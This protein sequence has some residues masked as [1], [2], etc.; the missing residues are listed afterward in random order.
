MWLVFT[1]RDLL[2]VVNISSLLEFLYMLIQSEIDWQI[3]SSNAN[4]C[5]LT[6][7]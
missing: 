7:N 6:D 3:R 1:A 5:C 4:L 2:I